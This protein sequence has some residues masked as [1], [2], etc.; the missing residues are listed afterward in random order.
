MKKQYLHENIEVK[1]TGRCATRQ[2]KRPAGIPG[3]PETRKGSVSLYEITPVDETCGSW[4]KWVALSE[5]YIINDV[6]IDN[7]LKQIDD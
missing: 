4:K 1:L 6:D 7:I 5:L 3:P 2:R